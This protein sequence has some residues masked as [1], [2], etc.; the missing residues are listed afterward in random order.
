MMPTAVSASRRMGC[1]QAGP[2][3][4]PATTNTTAVVMGMAN[5]T[6]NDGADPDERDHPEDIERENEKV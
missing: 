6:Q 5:Q 2:G 4:I 1:I 3:L